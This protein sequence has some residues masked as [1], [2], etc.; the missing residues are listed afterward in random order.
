VC[1]GLVRL[2][3]EAGVPE[4]AVQAVASGSDASL[5]DLLADRRLAGVAFAGPEEL[6]RAINRVLASRDGPII[7]P[8]VQARNGEAASSPLPGGPHYLHRF[9][10]EHALSIDTTAAGGNASLLSIGD[11]TA[12]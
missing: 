12:G 10:T 11:E 9:A 8:I 6:A 7:A 1:D 2:L 3:H 5:E 4:D